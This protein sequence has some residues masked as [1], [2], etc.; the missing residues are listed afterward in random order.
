MYAIIAMV[1][2]FFGLF[3][4]KVGPILVLAGILHTLG[5]INLSGIFIALGLIQV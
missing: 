1:R 4:Y 5:I 3:I 2:I